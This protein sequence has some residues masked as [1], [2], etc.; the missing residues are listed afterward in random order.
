MAY[1]LWLIIIIIIIII[2]Y[3]KIYCYY[4]ECSR[5]E[6][7]E[8]EMGSCENMHSAILLPLQ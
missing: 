1:V 6:T 7:A 3:L 8:L 4:S 2:I 5:I